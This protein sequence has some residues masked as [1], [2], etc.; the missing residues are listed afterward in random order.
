V[1][2]V[3]SYDFIIDNIRF[4]YSSTSTFDNCAYSFKL[5]YL[6]AVPR[7]NNYYAEYG[8]L[9]HECFEQYFSGNLE[10]FE[11]SHYYRDNYD[12]IIKSPPQTSELGQRYK[13]QGQHFFDNFSF[14]KSDYCVLLSEDKIDFEID[15]IKIVAKPDLLLRN[16]E[17]NKVTLY[18]YKTAAPFRTD[19]RTG[20]EIADKKKLEGY[21]KQIFIYAY[22][23]RNHKGIPID[24]IAIWF[25]RLDRTVTIPWT[26]E[27]E[28]EAMR[29]LDSSI[30]KIKAEEIFAYNN[31]NPFFC[32][33]LCSVR[34]YCEYR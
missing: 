33:N 11:I 18:D 4:S 12:V 34:K 15:G 31:S 21:Y 25:P 13:E 19:K 24:E 16:K 3:S 23:V 8:L 20:K 7:E 17:T 28:D 32:E 9:I 5:T 1:V 29:W 30:K 27:K 22:A 10:M 26:Q 6:D 2:T 14:D